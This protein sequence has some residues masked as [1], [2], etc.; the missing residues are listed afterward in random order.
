MVSNISLL[1]NLSDISFCDK[2]CSNVNNDSTKD[3]II[4]YIQDKLNVNIIDRIYMVLR[5]NYLKNICYNQHVVSL[6]SHGNPYLLYLTKIDG[7]NYCF[8][9]D[10]KLKINLLC[11][12]YVYV[13]H[14]KCSVMKKQGLRYSCFCFCCCC[15]FVFVC[16]V[17]VFVFLCCLVLIG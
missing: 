4:S 1:E 14:F 16:F 7:I 9:I 3:K 12:I 8:Y 13:S 5:P 2:Q 6:L 11:L 15:F 10:R 17:F